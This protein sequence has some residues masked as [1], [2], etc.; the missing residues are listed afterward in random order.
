M[1]TPH[2]PVRSFGEEEDDGLFFEDEIVEERDDS[3][4]R[5]LADD[6]IDIPDYDVDEAEE[7]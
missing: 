7:L 1:T 3:T 2:A 4:V 5:M 6:A